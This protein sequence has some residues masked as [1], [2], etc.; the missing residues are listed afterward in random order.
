MAV[1]TEKL[2]LFGQ[3]SS[4]L[5]ST[6][7]DL[8][9]KNVVVDPS[10]GADGETDVYLTKRPGMTQHSSDTAAAGRGIYEWKGNLYIVLGNKLYKDSVQIGSTLTNSAGL[11][12]FT[13]EHKTDL[14]VIQDGDKIITTD[15]STFTEQ[16]DGDIPSS[17]VPGVVY[18]DT[19]ICVM[20]VNGEVYNS[21]LD[22][23]TSWTAA[24]FLTAKLEPDD[25]VA[26]FKHRNYVAALGSWTLEFFYDAANAAGT[27]LAPVDGAQHMIGCA[28]A[29]TVYADEDTAIWVTRTRKGGSRVG[30]L[31]GLQVKYL[32]TPAIERIINQEGTDLNTS[33]AFG[34]RVNG[35]LLYLLTLPTSDVT[36]V[37]DVETGYW[38]E[39][40]SDPSTEAYFTGIGYAQMDG[41]HYILDEDNGKVYEMDFDI[42]Q[43]DTN[44]INVEIV[45][46]KWDGKSSR[47]KTIHR[48]DVV[49]DEQTTAS[50]ITLEMTIDDYQ[51]W[52]TA[53]TIDMSKTTPA[54]NQ[55][56]KAEKAAFRV[57][58]AA[59]TPLRLKELELSYS[60]G[61]H[62]G[63]SY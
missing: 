48:V 20:N 57:K 10:K 21:D 55:F 61:K 5:G 32:S 13:E 18:I 45:T 34:M 62:N 2:P 28:A 12:Y 27:P 58:H 39:W 6:S 35:R 50:N 31:Q 26:L 43:D 29:N 1:R 24:S 38:T 63:G 51:N 53:R 42:Y 44:D 46:D 16:T 33:R 4:R 22:D 49:G 60:L 17:Q 52:S 3:Y 15:G 59:N 30:I 54:A 56:G 8:R 14:L 47:K 23:V 11:V 36:L 9:L 41:K 19:Y 37:C 40:T 25:G 7:K